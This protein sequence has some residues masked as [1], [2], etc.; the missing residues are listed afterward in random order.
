[1]RRFSLCG[2]L[3][4]LLALVAWSASGRTPLPPDPVE[5]LLET[6]SAKRW[7]QHVFR[8]SEN[9]GTWSRFTFRV[10]EATIYDGAPPPDDALDQAA[11]YLVRELQAYGYQ[12]VEQVFSHTRYADLST[13]QAEYR[14]RNVIAEKPGRGPHRDRIL[15]LTAHYDSIASN[16]EGWEETWRTMIAPGANDNASGVATL[17]EVARVLAPLP[18]DATVRFVF[19]AGEEIGLFGSQAYAERIGTEASSLLGVLNLDMVGQEQDGNFDLHAVGDWRSAWLLEALE[20]VHRR[21]SLGLRL[22]L[23][24]DSENRFSDHASFWEIGVPAVLISEEPMPHASSE[25]DPTYHT[26]ADLPN[27]LNPSYGVAVGRFVLAAALFLAG[28]EEGSLPA[29]S[30]MGPLLAVGIYPN[31]YPRQEGGQLTIQ[32]QL[33][34]DA[35]V[36]VAVYDLHGG[37]LAQWEFPEGSPFGRQ[38]LSPPLLWRPRDS[39]GSPLAAGSYVVSVEAK[40]QTTSARGTIRLLIVPSVRLLAPYRR[41][42]VGVGP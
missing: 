23:H 9:R 35:A 40:T 26:V 11:D 32:Y 3:G 41:S 6:L 18:L 31:P 12:V 42:R 36:G 15:L 30:A 8:L 13:K 17:L 1:M 7:Q 38:G 20:E 5:P 14:M 24:Q 25:W 33:N 4:T 29:P 37:L 16:S 34:Q 2:L 19:F 28:L 10:R 39:T 27:H 21:W 22:V